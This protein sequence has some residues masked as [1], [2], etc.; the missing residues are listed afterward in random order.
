MVIKDGA[1]TI[2]E[3]GRF[4]GRGAYLCAEKRCINALRNKK[5]KL[6]HS[7]RAS[8]ARDVEDAFLKGLLSMQQGEE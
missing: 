3:D 1:L 6:S 5:G 7:L 2:D 4:P 8:I